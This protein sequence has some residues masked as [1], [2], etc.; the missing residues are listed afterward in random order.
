MPTLATFIQHSIGSTSQ[1]NQRRKGNKIHPNGRGRSKTVST[2]RCLD[3]IYRKPQRLHQ[4]TIRINKFSKVAGY[5]I[6]K[7]KSV[8]FLYT[9]ELSETEIKK[10]IPFTAASKRINGLRI[11]ITK[12]VKDL[13]S[14]N[15]KT[16][17]KELKTTQTNG[18]IFCA[19]G[20]EELIFFK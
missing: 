4:K 3:T 20:L 6:D 11:N 1:S 19:H 12:E 17:T 8:V 16:L 7:W 9:D 13:F 15:Y 10:T 14:E 18:K 2:C 5:K